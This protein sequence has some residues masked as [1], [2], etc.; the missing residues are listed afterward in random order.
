MCG[1]PAAH[2]ARQACL[3]PNRL[4][5]RSR[6]RPAHPVGS[7]ASLGRVAGDHGKLAAWRGTGAGPGRALSWA[8]LLLLGL[9]QAPRQLIEIASADQLA[10]GGVAARRHCPVVTG[11]TATPNPPPGVLAPQLPEP[12][13][14][15]GS[16]PGGGHGK[17]QRAAGMRSYADTRGTS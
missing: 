7:T 15:S 4:P 3:S 16:A 6:L 9:G 5:G 8:M 14:L 10:P 11:D 2:P 12:G 17:S 1:R 13:V